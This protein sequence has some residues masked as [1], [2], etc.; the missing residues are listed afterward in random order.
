R[1]GLCRS[2]RTQ[3]NREGEVVTRHAVSGVVGTSMH[4]SRTAIEALAKIAVG[5]L[6]RLYH[7]VACGQSGIIRVH[8][9]AA[10]RTIGSAQPTTDAMVLDDDRKRCL[11]GARADRPAMD[12]IDRTAEQ[13]RGVVGR[14]GRKW[15][16]IL[17][18]SVAR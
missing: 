9:D 13:E 11:A 2:E 15:D 3:A 6:L 4:A 16:G 7:G 18:G 10:E 8:V 14:G 17:V 5:R 12:G 1:G